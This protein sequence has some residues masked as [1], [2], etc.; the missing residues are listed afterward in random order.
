GEE[1]GIAAEPDVEVALYEAIDRE[2]AADRLGAVDR[3]SF[4]GEV[5]LVE[6]LVE[7]GHIDDRQVADSNRK[8]GY[9]LCLR[10]VV[11]GARHQGNDAS[12]QDRDD[13]NGGDQQAP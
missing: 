13:S 8:A 11:P 2:R 3:Q 7:R 12:A 1:P 4:V 10:R 5:A 9:G 6:G